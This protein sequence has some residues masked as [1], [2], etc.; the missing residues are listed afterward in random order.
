MSKEIKCKECGFTNP[1]SSKFCNN[2]GAK[3]PLSTH[4]ICPN[5]ETPNTRDRVFCDTC[6]T[7]LIPET[8]QLKPEEPEASQPPTNEPFSLPTRRPGETGELDPN[9][10]PDW[11]RTGN[12][13]STKGEVDVPEDEDDAPEKKG[14]SDLPD[15]LVHDSDPEPIINAPTTISTEFYQDLLNKADDLPQPDDL[16]ADEEE[17]DLPDW[18]SDAAG[19]RQQPQEPADP[20]AGLTSWLN[21][22][23]DESEDEDTAVSPEEPGD[24][25]S[26]GLTDWLQE[27]DD[28]GETGDEH[29]AENAA[30]LEELLGEADDDEADDWLQELGPAQTDIFAPQ[31]DERENL[32]DDD[33]LPG[34]MDELGPLQTNLLNPEQM[35]ELTG[36]LTGLSDD[37]DIFAEDETGEDISFTDLFETA[38]SETEKLPDW[39]DA[40]AEE[41]ETFLSDL[42][43]ELAEEDA[44][45]D[46]V[47]E[48]GSDWFTVDQIVAETEL[49]WLE[50]TGN[51]GNLPDEAGA[52]VSEEPEAVDEFSFDELPDDEFDF[53]LLDE[54]AGED[55]EAPEPSAADDDLDWLSDMEAIQTGK[56]VVE[57]EEE[58]EE[59]AVLDEP[60]VEEAP[61]FEAEPE[62]ADDS[63]ISDDFFA[64]T[65]VGEDLPAWLEQLDKPKEVEEASELGSA[66]TD[67][68][69]WIAS[70]RP[71]QGI[72]GSELP[73]V[74]A[75]M[76]LRDTLEGIPEEL[77]GAELP[78]WLQGAPLDTDIPPPPVSEADTEG[79][80]EI[81]DWLQPE[82]EDAKD[83]G[84]P[85]SET[86]EPAATSTSRNEWRSLLEELP[87]LTPLA[88]TLPKAEIPEWVQQLKPTELSGE[89]PREPDGLAE[90][91]GPLQGMQGVVTIEPTIARPRTAMLPTPYIT[92]PEQEQQVALLRQITQ[93]MPETVTTLSAKSAYGTAA[94]LRLSLTVLLI[95]AVLAGLFGP[96]LVA[97]RLPVSDN[98]QAFETAVTA[99]A[100]QPVLIAIEYTPAMAGELTPQAEL[101]LAQ[102]AANNSP[103]L[104][105]SQ[106]AAGTAVATELVA[107]D[108]AQMIGYLPGEGIGLRQLGDCL[109]GRVAC[110]Q[111]N[112]R[113]LEPELQTSLSQVGLI[114]LLTGDRDNLVNWVEQVGAVATNVPLV[115]GVTQALTPLASSY[116]GTE[117]LS[118]LLGGTPDAAAYEQ[119]INASGS[120]V[121][122]RLNAQIFGQ[123]L[124]GALLLIGLVAYGTTG[125][126]N[127]RRQK[128]VG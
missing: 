108:A 112:G 32:A 122:T 41:G 119:L 64:E 84:T 128:K 33:D 127:N 2:C 97:T 16:F 52:E 68:P 95:L 20:G 47:S 99:A 6:G 55:T 63:W 19:T 118:G 62:P 86:L 76:D 54:L 49:D 72:I 74:L 104:I 5:C 103:V 45:P 69:E 79:V 94:W 114:I 9:A 8:S 42:P 44:G 43:P 58:D 11:L 85:P 81:P 31:A 28:L 57:P 48:P 123:L 37:D 82:G 15:W 83:S 29:E 39:L 98:V 124:A 96:D 126:M 22:L 61:A 50:E 93:E 4:I 88:E 60:D 56:L 53:D 14:T 71:G 75:D 23:R 3:L 40:A 67:L 7:R 100:G 78:E 110:E 101:L 21:D 111:L 117:Q 1:H 24:D 38:G 102:L 125:L 59:T 92:T 80:L 12:I 66:D 121:R 115:A 120:E 89:P 90:T 30:A 34:W 77:A 35:A 26:G 18:L 17:A 25:V 106:Y 65:A 107:S 73:D 105:I 109:G 70:M 51:L 27:L 13:A 36:P 113:M 46:V 116:A 87:P 91:T 10:V